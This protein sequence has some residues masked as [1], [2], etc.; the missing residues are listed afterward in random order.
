MP[1]TSPLPSSRSSSVPPTVAVRELREA[2]E[3]LVRLLGPLRRARAVVEH[4]DDRRQLQGVVERL[5][6]CL[7]D[8]E[9]CLARLENGPEGDRRR[10]YEQARRE[11]PARS[12]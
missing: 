2:V 8:A 6:A 10:A 1:S 3:R 11:R 12:W 7:T 5:E 4:E 9:S